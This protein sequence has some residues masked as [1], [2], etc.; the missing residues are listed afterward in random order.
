MDESQTFSLIN[1][2]FGLSPLPSGKGRWK[3][4]E[5]FSTTRN[6]EKKRK[7]EEKLFYG[8]TCGGD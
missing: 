3:E 4:K 8:K 5:T 1:I 7:Q 2:N 6:F